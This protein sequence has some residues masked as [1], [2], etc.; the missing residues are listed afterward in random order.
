MKTAVY[1]GS[2]DPITLGHV[3]IIQRGSRLVENLIVGIGVNSEK[4]GL[5]KPDERLQLV[6]RCV[7]DLPHVSVKTFA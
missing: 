3:N 6:E 7:A 5:F 2:F 4:Q 1:T